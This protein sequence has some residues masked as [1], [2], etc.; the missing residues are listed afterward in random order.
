MGVNFV[1]E[2]VLGQIRAGLIEKLTSEQRLKFTGH[3]FFKLEGLIF[4]LQFVPPNL[5]NSLIVYST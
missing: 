2:V 3:T 5:T 1:A 4:N